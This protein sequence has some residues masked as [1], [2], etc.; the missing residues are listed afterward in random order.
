METQKLNICRG[1]IKCSS[2]VSLKYSIN[3]TTIN[4][5]KKTNDFLENQLSLSHSIQVHTTGVAC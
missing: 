3:A 2:G 1:L 5:I 4:W